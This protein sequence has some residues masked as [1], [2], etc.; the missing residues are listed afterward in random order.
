MLGG[1]R[2]WHVL[3]RHE[4]VV[5]LVR[6]LSSTTTSVRLLLLLMSIVIVRI[7]DLLDNHRWVC[8]GTSVFIKQGASQLIVAQSA[9]QYETMIQVKV[10]AWDCDISLQWILACE[11]ENLLCL[12]VVRYQMVA[13]RE[14]H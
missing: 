13:N 8:R 2:L 10:T 1:H 14:T 11:Y 4:M 5:I 7:Y 6:H 12:G 9:S 3:M